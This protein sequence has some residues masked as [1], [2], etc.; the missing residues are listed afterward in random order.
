MTPPHDQGGVIPLWLWQE[1]K[2]TR[3][4]SAVVQSNIVINLT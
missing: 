3:R 4:N 2:R 1:T